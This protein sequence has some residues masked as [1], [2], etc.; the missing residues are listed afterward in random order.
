[1]N[2]HLSW[3]LKCALHCLYSRP[4]PPPPGCADIR[5]ADHFSTCSSWTLQEGSNS[6]PRQ[7]RAGII[8]SLLHQSPRL[9]SRSES[10]EPA[11][12][13]MRRLC[14]PLSSLHGDLTFIYLVLASFK[15]I[16]F[17]L[18]LDLSFLSSGSLSMHRSVCPA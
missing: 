17:S 3:C 12:G 9:R 16:N 4:P 11:P 13:E 5:R 2:F 8:F 14:K 10:Q 15:T 6:V 1:M 18:P 7:Q